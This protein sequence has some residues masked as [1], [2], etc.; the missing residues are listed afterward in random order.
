MTARLLRSDGLVALRHRGY[1]I[2]FYG[3]LARG[4]GA[5]MQLVAIPWL[6]VELEA[7]PLE[8]GIVTA[9][10][11]AST[12][13][14]APFG[15]VLADRVSR[16]TVLIANQLAS[17]AHA[18]ALF[19]LIATD[20]LSIGVLAVLALLFGLL[21]A[22]EL[23]V[24]Q[25][26]LTE[27]VPPEEVTSAV[28]LHATAWNVTRFVGP[29]VAGLLIGTLGVAS[30]FVVAGI[31]S[32]GVTVSLVIL[33][34]FPHHRRPR[35]AP[36]GGVVSSLVAGVRFAL[37]ERRVRWAMAILAAAGI[38]GIQSFQTLAPLYV[39]E[40]LELGGGA[41]GAFMSAWGAGALVA[42]F[43][44]T[45]LA[46]G[47]RARW[48]IGGLAAL[49]ILLACLSLIASAPVAYGIAAL[50]GF[51]QI[52]VVQNSLVTVQY[53]ATDEY[54]GR[55]MGLYT[56]VLQGSIP[57]GALLAGALAGLLGVTGA[58]LVGAAGL[59]AVA[60]GALKAAPGAAVASSAPAD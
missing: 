32:L 17:L 59:A 20:S 8:L 60:I 30:C 25:A 1:R 34:R 42:A 40:I 16:D 37:H 11:F 36:T 24:R 22:V 55:L 33:T 44:V 54:R 31:A 47:D 49:A 50:L 29:A 10:L 13:I 48:L 51:A 18:A 21:V 46:R 53:A 4:I 57:F 2:Y 19:T 9:C 5:W 15:G 7:T 43:A 41:F 6:A 3:M 35:P 23:P 38:F 14:I 28:S 58:M 52:A 45:L 27:F 26:F 12:V 56:T 39:A